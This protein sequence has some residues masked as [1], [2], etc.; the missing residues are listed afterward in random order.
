MRKLRA[1]N[2]NREG[3]KMKSETQEE[4]HQKYDKFA[5]QMRA[6]MKEMRENQTGEEWEKAADLDKKRKEEYRAR[7]TEEEKTKCNE[8][9]KLRKRK[10]RAKRT[11]EERKKDCEADRERKNKQKGNISDEE[12]DFGRIMGKHR[13]RELRMSRTG[14]QKLLENLKSKKGMRILNEEGRLHEYEIRGKQ[15]L[16]EMSDWE[17]YIKRG[18]VQHD[19]AK[20]VIPDIVQKINQKTRDE[21]ERER[22]RKEEEKNGVWNYSGESGEWYWTGKKGSEKIDHFCLSPPTEEEKEIIKLAEQKEFEQ[23][24]EQQSKLQKEKRK[25]KLEERKAAM[26][27][28]LAPLPQRELCAYEKMR[29]ANIKE[30]KD[31]M[32]A[33]DFFESLRSMKA[34]FGFVAIGEKCRKKDAKEKS[35]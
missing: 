1:K 7:Q 15:N 20:E 31:A 28:P 17:K 12:S 26:A 8:A 10:Q 25:Q 4:L 22:K 32:D 9:D 14:K 35:A 21:K 3:T 33:N 11:E 19:L 18:K 13:K 24:V 16:S 30:R 29:E 2:K 23:Y 6:N 5:K 34:D 27:I